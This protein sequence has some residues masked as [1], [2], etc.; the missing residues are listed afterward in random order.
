MTRTLDLAISH[1]HLLQTR[2]RSFARAAVSSTPL[3]LAEGTGQR[4]QWR[5]SAPSPLSHPILPPPLSLLSTM[6]ATPASEAGAADIKADDAGSHGRILV[7]DLGS[8][9]TGLIGKALALIAVDATICAAPHGT[10]AGT[11]TAACVRAAFDAEFTPKSDVR[12]IVLS[13]SPASVNDDEGKAYTTVVE[14][15]LACRR[16]HADATG[17]VVPVLAVCFGF[18]CLSVLCGGSVAKGPGEYG[19]ALVQPLSPLPAA[20]V[21][22][23]WAAALHACM[24]GLSKDRLVSSKLQELGEGSHRSVSAGGASAG[25][26]GAGAGGGAAVANGGSASPSGA[27]QRLHVW[28]SHGDDVVACGSLHAV[29]MG[30][31]PAIAAAA[32]AELR[33]LALQYH[34]EHAQTCDDAGSDVLFLFARYC[35]VA[36]RYLSHEERSERLLTTTTRDVVRDV[37]ALDAAAA[38]RGESPPHFIVAL[39]G[40]V[41]SAV[42]AGLV[43]HSL[44]ELAVAQATSEDTAVHRLHLCYVNTGLMRDEDAAHVAALSKALAL[45]VETRDAQEE[46]FAELAGVLDDQEVRQCVGRSFGRLLARERRAYG[47]PTLLVQGTL[48]SDVV[49]STRIKAHHNVGALPADLKAHVFEPL[50]SLFKSDVRRLAAS[51]GLGDAFVKRRPFPG[52]GLALRVVAA[53]VNRENVA[54]AR[55]ANAIWRDVLQRHNVP[56][57]QSVAAVCPSVSF[58]GVRGDERTRGCLCMLRAVVTRDFMTAWP[59]DIPYD[60]LIEAQ[61]AI[62]KGVPAVG[63]VVY[64]VTSK[65]PACVEFR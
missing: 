46:F 57:A 34:P 3:E 1:T 17:T 51:L 23:S 63:R 31:G 20:S 29:A 45:P 55:A 54:M 38:A 35:G 30:K 61:S 41:D 60:V 59:A 13:G 32:S 9:T 65:P 4:N 22:D 28:S 27:V 6:A 33:V 62:C 42:A 21:D 7:V 53:E 12:G 39:S 43:A 25:A 49:E 40:G 14:H 37:A 5:I 11:D 64:D 44:R 48:A 8:Q 36:P 50:R 47:E 58:V 18:Q 10:A 24:C 16:R 52:P 2:R 15:V 26:G 56:H 19:S